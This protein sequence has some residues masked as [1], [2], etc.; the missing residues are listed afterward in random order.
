MRRS[1]TP[2]KAFDGGDLDLNSQI[3]VAGKETSVGRLKYRFA[4]V[5]EALLAV[6]R[7]EIDMQD[8][9]TVKVKGEMLDDQPGPPLLRPHGRGDALRR[10]WR[11]SGLDD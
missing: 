5:D 11:G 4:D 3:T 2:S 9:V 6:E 10:R 8:T 7:G 1:Q